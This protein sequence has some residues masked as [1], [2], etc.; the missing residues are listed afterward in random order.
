MHNLTLPVDVPVVRPPL[1]YDDA[2][3]MAGSCFTEH[4]SDKL[5]RY[6]YNVLSHPFGITY[7]PES[8]AVAF[9]RIASRAT[10][11]ISDLVH[12]DGLYH[13]M[14]H[15]GKYSGIDPEHVVEKINQEILLAHD[16]L[17]Q[18][19]W[20]SVSPGTSR[21]YRY[22]P[23]DAVVANCHKIPSNQFNEE[24]LSAFQCR[25]AY[26]RIYT[27][28]RKVAPQCQ[29]IWT[30]SPVRHIKDGLVQNQRSKAA[31]IA[32]FDEF[33][34]AHPDVHYFPAYEIMMDELRDYRFYARDLV[35]PSP[36][37]IDIIWEKFAAAYLDE[38][39]RLLH[40]A[41]EQ[42]RRAMEHRFFHQDRESIRKFASIQLKHIDELAGRL[43]QLHW[44]PERQYFFQYLE[45]D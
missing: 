27:A 22:K 33:H 5:L 29:L 17:R 3:L 39:D 32:G 7:N 30:I 1:T 9:E 45:L 37:A 14:D 28:V 11:S 36:L 4:I 38:N 18:C 19:Q 10:Y 34:Q 44:Q 24:H 23:T 8:L 25:D 13:S 40:P 12:Q 35:H 15:H 42:I 20:V 16:H 6:K 31:L 43:P 21:I 2:I 26:E 41:I